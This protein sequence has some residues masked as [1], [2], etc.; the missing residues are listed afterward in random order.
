MRTTYVV[1]YTLRGHNAQEVYFREDFPDPESAEAFISRI[2]NAVAG[3]QA[4]KVTGLFE[5]RAA[6]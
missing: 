4:Y 6:S 3:E 1:T 5:L 2:D